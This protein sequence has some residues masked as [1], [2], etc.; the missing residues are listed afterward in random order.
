[1]AYFRHQRKW[2]W[3]LYG[4]Q[5]L[6]AGWS[7]AIFAVLLVSGDFVANVVRHQLPSLLKGEIYIGDSLVLELLLLAVV[8][9]AMAIM[10][11]IEHRSVWSSYGFSG[12]R[13]IRNLLF[14]FG[15]GFV[16]LSLVVGA[17]YAGGFLVFDGRALQGLPALGYGL[18]WLLDFTIVGLREEALFR[19]YLQATLTR[20]MGFWPAAMVLSLWFGA[21]HLLNDGENLM[22]IVGVVAHALFYILLL[23]LSG[24]L[25]LGIGF[26]AAWDWAQSY[27][28]GTPQSGHMMQGHLLLAHAQGNSLMSGGSAGPEGSLLGLPMQVIG[29]FAFLWVVK[30]AGLFVEW[31]DGRALHTLQSLK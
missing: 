23:R 12:P 9:G 3:I 6:R 8:S 15:G 11:R 31:P 5:G 29:V 26:H 7:V 25:W 10:G 24:S 4:S 22:G 16:C 14:G 17:L 28:F 18:I 21:S 20:G 1:M 2:R 30:R 19:G 27:L 13:P